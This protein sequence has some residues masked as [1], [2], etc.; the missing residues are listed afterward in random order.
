[1]CLALKEADSAPVPDKCPSIDKS[2]WL[3]C[4]LQ[5]KYEN[6]IRS[7][8]TTDKDQS[9]VNERIKNNVCTF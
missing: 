5:T 8:G 4:L 2:H 7:Y 6:A 9:N 1:M 3:L